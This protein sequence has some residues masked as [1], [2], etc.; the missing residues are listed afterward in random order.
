M[1]AKRRLRLSGDA[2]EKLPHSDWHFKEPIVN[3]PLCG[4]LL[5]L[6]AS[7][8][9]HH[10]IPRS[11]GG[12]EKYRI[13]RIC[14]RKIHATFTEKE[15]ASEYSTWEALKLNP[16]LQTFIKW[17][18]KRPADFMDNSRKVARLRT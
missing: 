6:G 8:D 5:P 13:H 4:R 2:L 14:H 1:V 16:E 9:D 18:A 3:C 15:L 17:V 10:L 12:K 11:Q 7:V